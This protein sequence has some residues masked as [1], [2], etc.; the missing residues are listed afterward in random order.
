[1]SMKSFVERHTI[2]FYI[3]SI[4]PWIGGARNYNSIN[5]LEFTKDIIGQCPY[6][7]YIIKQQ[8]N[9]D[10]ATVIGFTQL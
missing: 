5:H 3:T 6:V 10:C 2:G 4:L 8:L 1:M 7:L 9:S